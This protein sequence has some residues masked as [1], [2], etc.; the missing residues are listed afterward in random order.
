MKTYQIWKR[1]DWGNHFMG[2]HVTARPLPRQ[3]IAGRLFNSHQLRVLTLFPLDQVF[4]IETT[5]KKTP[6]NTHQNY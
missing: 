5:E 1:N 6:C 3:D 2:R 4:T